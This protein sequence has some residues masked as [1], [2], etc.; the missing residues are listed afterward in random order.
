LFAAAIET[1]LPVQ[2]VMIRYLRDDRHYPDMTFLR[3]EHFMANL[4]R[5]LRQRQCIADVSILLAIDPAGKRRRELA[6]E[7]EA[8]VRAAFERE[9]GSDE[10]KFAH[11]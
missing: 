6:L 10:L 1:N 9:N 7:A 2:P 3:G 8:A 4:F 11:G 5:L